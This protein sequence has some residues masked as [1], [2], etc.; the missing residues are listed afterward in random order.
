MEPIVV[1][2]RKVISGEPGAL[3]SFIELFRSKVYQYSYLNCG[4]KEDAEEV[5]QETLVKICEHLH[6]LR[7]PEHV[8]AWVFRIARNICLTR[9]RKNAFESCP[10]MSLE[11]IPGHWEDLLPLRATLP[12]QAAYHHELRRLLAQ[13]IHHLPEHYRTVVIL[14]DLEDLSVEQ[15]AQILD[16]NPSVVKTR[17]HRARA[18]LRKG[19]ERKH[20][21]VTS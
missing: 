4:R 6:E 21:S 3:D 15:T 16:L 1:L 7:E 17:L 2:A 5:A 12:D 9:R 11:E 13:L 14:R 10:R 20:I 19:L 8:K 18:M